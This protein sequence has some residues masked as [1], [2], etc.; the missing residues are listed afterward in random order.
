MRNAP[1]FKLAVR[2]L[3][4]GFL[5]CSSLAAGQESE[6]ASITTS[7]TEVNLTANYWDPVLAIGQTLSDKYGINLSV[8]SPTWDFPKDAE[9]VSLADPNYS[10][11]HP[12]VHY[13]VMKPHILQVRFNASDVHDRF[14]G[15]ERINPADV[16][17]L[18]RQLVDVANRA[19]PYAYRL[20]TDGDGYS[21][22]PTRTRNSTGTVEDV[23]PLLDRH[24]TI[25][26][27]KR[28]IY[29]HA[30]L[31]AEQLSKQTGLHVSCCQ[32]FVSGVAWGGA[33]VFYGAEDKPAREVLETLIRLDQESS[34]IRLPR[35]YFDHWVVRCDGTGSPWCAIDVAS[36]FGYGCR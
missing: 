30:M 22:V 7:G 31:L 10:A 8:E 17:P 29:Q 26:P 25:P 20:D 6:C 16:V 23:Q 36:T 34:T 14:N 13:L 32:T 19:M 35:P 27:A 3:T 9:D 33:S 1:T 5:L 24:V 2:V 11:Q 15:A 4:C 18:L 28:P 21:L 12:K